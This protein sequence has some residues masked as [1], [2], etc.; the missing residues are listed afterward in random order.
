LIKGLD[1]EQGHFGHA[2]VVWNICV[3]LRAQ[4]WE[5]GCLTFIDGVFYAAQDSVTLE[6][7]LF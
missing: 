4:F 1:N 7:G 5:R 3:K 6:H 2:K